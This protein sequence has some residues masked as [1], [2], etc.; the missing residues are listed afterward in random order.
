M[1]TTSYLKSI[2]ELMQ[3]PGFYGNISSEEVEKELKSQGKDTYLIRLSS[4][5]VG[6][7][8]L[9]TYKKGK[10]SHIKI[11]VQ[12]AGGYGAE[13]TIQKKEKKKEI[14][15]FQNKSLKKLVAELVSQLKIK[16]DPS[17]PFG[18]IF[19]TKERSKDDIPL[20]S[21][22]LYAGVVEI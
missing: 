14:K 16:N 11:D 8:A 20:D 5:T 6:A 3:L 9:S 4:S 2:I 13:M 19:N 17:S 10:V 7:F 1:D 18:W 22:N 21:T 12:A 15:K